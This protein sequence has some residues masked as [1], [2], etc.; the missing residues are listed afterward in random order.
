[1]AAT[2][3]EPGTSERQEVPPREYAAFIDQIELRSIW[4]QNAGLANH[5]GPEMP[6]KGVFDFNSRARWEHDPLGFR[7]LHTYTVT[8]KSADATLAELEVTFAVD[9]DSKEP[10]T[11]A[12]FGVFEA[13]N[14]PVNTWP[15]LREFVAS[16]LGRFGWAPF[17]IPAFKVGARP[18]PRRRR[19][20]QG[21]DARPGRQAQALERS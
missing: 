12:I 1:M 21:G 6:D 7:A 20:K 18:A 8:L 19:G 10:M 5:H 13:V 9:Y 11:D 2:P 17:T 14:L 4:I 16:T 15:F 3:P